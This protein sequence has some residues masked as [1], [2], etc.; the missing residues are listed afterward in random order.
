MSPPEL[1][2]LIA[3]SFTI[4][5]AVTGAVGV[6][7]SRFKRLTRTSDGRALADVVEANS[8][9]LQT[10]ADRIESIADDVRDLRTHHGGLEQRV[11]RLE[12]FLHSSSLRKG[13]FS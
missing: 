4:V 2:D 13:W 7:L 9:V 10:L 12:Q 11:S 1:L 3:T 8:G 5:T 6:I